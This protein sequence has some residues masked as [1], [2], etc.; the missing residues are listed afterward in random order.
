MV[1]AT[2]QLRQSVIARCNDA[3]GEWEA[4]VSLRHLGAALFTN[5]G[6]SLESAFKEMLLPWA[7]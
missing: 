3:D 7:Q 6:G 5:K 1:I 2:S 4:S